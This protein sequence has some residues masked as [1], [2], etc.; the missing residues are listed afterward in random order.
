LTV[1]RK[2]KDKTARKIEQTV[3]SGAAFRLLDF[4]NAGNWLFEFPGCMIVIRAVPG[5]GDFQ[6]CSAGA[7]SRLKELGCIARSSN[8]RAENNRVIAHIWLITTFGQLMR[9]SAKQYASHFV[10]TDVVAQPPSAVSEKSEE[11]KTQPRAAVPQ[12]KPEGVV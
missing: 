7:F 3:L 11:T 8:I 6:I 10:A 5:D 1:D 12:V 2:S 4:L 9:K